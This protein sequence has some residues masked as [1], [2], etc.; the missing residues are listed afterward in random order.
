MERHSSQLPLHTIFGSNRVFGDCFTPVELSRRKWFG[1]SASCCSVSNGM[2]VNGLKLTMLSASTIN[3]A[4][5]SSFGISVVCIAAIAV[6]TDLT[7]RSHAPPICGAAGGLNTHLV[8]VLV[9]VSASCR[10]ISIISLRKSLFAPTK[11]VP[12]SLRISTGAPLRPM[13][14][15]IACLHDS[16]ESECAT[17]RCTARVVRHV[18]SAIHL[19]TVLRFTRTDIGPK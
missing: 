11:F 3:V 1:V 18:N 7:K 17:S 4:R 19:F 8:F 16:V 12:L 15:R 2:N 14:R 5:A 9:N 10:S 6:L 13:K